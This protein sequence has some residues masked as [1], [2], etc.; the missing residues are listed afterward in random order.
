M[1]TTPKQSAVTDLERSDA[2]DRLFYL[3]GLFSFMVFVGSVIG[4][5]HKY[6]TSTPI[7]ESCR[8]KCDQINGTTVI[9]VTDRKCYCVLK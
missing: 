9:G 4:S 3:G 5:C 8:I 2:L 7:H 1:R 6:Q